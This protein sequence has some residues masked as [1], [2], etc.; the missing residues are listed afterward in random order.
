MLRTYT[1]SLGE[2]WHNFA[3]VLLTILHNLK[4][5]SWIFEFSHG[6]PEYRSCWWS[7][8]I[9]I[10][11]QFYVCFFL[12]S[13]CFCFAGGQVLLSPASLFRSKVYGKLNGLLAWVERT[14]GRTV[15]DSFSA[16]CLLKIVKTLRFSQFWRPSAFHTDVRKFVVI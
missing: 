12:P 8:K 15:S 14:R 5:R 1:S 2:F 4:C 16:G 11:L 6:I 13:F 7:V 3:F 9:H 10:Q